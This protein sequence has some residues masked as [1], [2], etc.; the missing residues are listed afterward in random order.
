MSVL[1]FSDLHC[2]AWPR[3]STTL[4]DGTNS[5][6]ADLLRV[7]DQVGGIVDERE[8]STLVIGGDVTHRRGFVQFSTYTLIGNWLRGLRRPKIVILEGNHDIETRGSGSLGPL[9]WIDGVETVCGSARWIEL[10]QFGYAYFV[11][12]MLGEA[13][14]VA[15]RN[16][17]DAAPASGHSRHAFLHY[18]LDGTILTNEYAV[19]S[20]LRLSDCERF[21]RLVFGHVH[22]PS[23]EHDH[24]VLYGGA[25][26]HFD[27]GDVGPR[28]AWWLTRD[29]EPE[30]FELH[31]PRFVSATYPNLPTPPEDGGFLRVLGTPVSVA[32]DVQKS[33]RDL[34]WL[35]V[36]VIE[37]TI[38]HE[39][40]AILTQTMFASDVLLRDYVERRYADL[41]QESRAAIVE[42]GLSCLRD[43]QR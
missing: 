33:G 12:Y 3:Q 28:F 42:F 25:V 24:R 32:R 18:A 40:A 17:Q 14:A 27:F 31:A 2:H 16:A 36:T 20:A 22:A 37:Q 19:P 34:G 5:R 38:P 15:M 11:P 26:M 7:L 9:A 13:V 43:A 35:D 41:S 1:W 39:A 8:P 23:I 10:D 30:P 29:D 21:D 6:V 4:P